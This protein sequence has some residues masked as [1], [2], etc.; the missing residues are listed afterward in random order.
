MS[1]QIQTRLQM[2]KCMVPELEKKDQQIQV[3]N[4]ELQSLKH[5]NQKLLQE[6]SSLQAKNMPI[7]SNAPI[8]S[9]NNI[10]NWMTDEHIKSVFQCYSSHVSNIRKDII[11][12]EPNTTQILK[13]SSLY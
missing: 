9:Y 8:L 1:G 13:S 4:E 2:K 10:D 5:K 3:L 12:V 6:L 11:F 7:T